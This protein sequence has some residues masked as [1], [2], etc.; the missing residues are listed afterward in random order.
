MM[1]NDKQEPV[2]RSSVTAKRQLTTVKDLCNLS[3]DF[4]HEQKPTY[5][6]RRSGDHMQLPTTNKDHLR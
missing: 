1:V 4:E 6:S 3:Q 5:D 2:V